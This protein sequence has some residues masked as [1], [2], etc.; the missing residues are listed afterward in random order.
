MQEF[1]GYLKFC[2]K[3][4][5]ACNVYLARLGHEEDPRW[6]RYAPRIWVA[7]TT[8]R[9]VG[10]VAWCLFVAGHDEEDNGYGTPETG[11]ISIDCRRCGWNLAHTTLY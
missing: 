10:K 9:Q 4:D 6:A 2:W 5:W 3:E 11:C 1:I 7:F 8:L